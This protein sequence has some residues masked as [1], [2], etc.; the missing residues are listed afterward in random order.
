M[1]TGPSRDA[2]PSG[3][4]SRAPRPPVLQPVR[5]KPQSAQGLACE[6]VEL[7]DGGPNS[8]WVPSTGRPPPHRLGG[9]GPAPG[10]VLPRRALRSRGAQVL[11]SG[12]PRPSDAVRQKD[13]GPGRT[14]ESAGTRK[15]P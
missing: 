4:D 13:L 2:Q 3:S 15:S 10:D 6:A 9:H 7:L 14:G 1:A 11:S 8:P 12:R 5:P